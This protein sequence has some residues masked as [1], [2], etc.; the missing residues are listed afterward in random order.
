M[1][2]LAENTCKDI[3]ARLT[4]YL[5]NEKTMEEML[6]WRD[7]ELIFLEYYNYFQSEFPKIK[8]E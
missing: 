5:N 2:T 7:G 8:I 6:H 4:A 3:A 1:K